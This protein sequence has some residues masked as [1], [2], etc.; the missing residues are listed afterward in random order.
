M[1]NATG[2]IAEG[3]L[4]VEALMGVAYRRLLTMGYLL[5]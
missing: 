4:E 5:E 2:L 3:V 1:N